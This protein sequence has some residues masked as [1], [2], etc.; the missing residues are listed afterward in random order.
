MQINIEEIKKSTIALAQKIQNYGF[1]DPRDLITAYK[2]YRSVVKDNEIL[3]NRAMNL[4]KMKAQNLEDLQQDGEGD[5]ESPASPIG[6]Q[7]VWF[8]FISSRL[9]VYFLLQH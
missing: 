6:N 1:D 8:S 3:A 4:E 7:K 9:L 5:I 2:R